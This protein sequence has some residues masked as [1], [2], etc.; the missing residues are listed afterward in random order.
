V[1]DDDELSSRAELAQALG[2]SLDVG[3]IQRRVDFV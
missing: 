2:K 3:F 1:G